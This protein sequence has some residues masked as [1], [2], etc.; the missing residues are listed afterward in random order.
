MTTRTYSSM[1]IQRNPSCDVSNYN[2]VLNLVQMVTS[3]EATTLS[4]IAPKA[5]L[6]DTYNSGLARTA[7]VLEI[8][9]FLEIE[10]DNITQLEK[11]Y[12]PYEPLSVEWSN[13]PCCFDRL[14]VFFP[15]SFSLFCFFPSL[16]FPFPLQ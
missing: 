11:G 9:S 14:E 13:D 8:E 6:S 16:K 3:G 2:Q 15:S 1:N 10:A 12:C 5:Y 4:Q 7:C